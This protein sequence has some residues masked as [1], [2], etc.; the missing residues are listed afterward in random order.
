MKIFNWLF[1]KGWNTPTDNV[2]GEFI[3][4]TRKF[5]PV[6]KWT[7]AGRAGKTIHCP[8]CG[9]PVRVFNFSW[10]AL[11]CTNCKATVKKYQ[12]LIEKKGKK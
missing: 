9:G 10:Y 2:P 5:K 6:P 1:G 12:W 4:N 8:K 11:T 7:H 3:V